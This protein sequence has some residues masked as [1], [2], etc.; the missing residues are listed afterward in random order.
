MCRIIA[1]YRERRRQNRVQH[2]LDS[3]VA[4]ETASVATTAPPTPA[5]LTAMEQKAVRFE[6]MKSSRTHNA[7]RVLA[8]NN[9]FKFISRLEAGNPPKEEEAGWLKTAQKK[10]RRTQRRTDRINTSA[11]EIT[12]E[13]QMTGLYDRVDHVTKIVKKMGTEGDGFPPAP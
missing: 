11:V 3:Y 6:L 13:F 1:A 2:A 12:E 8:A 9:A 5:P 7:D 10:T 4:P